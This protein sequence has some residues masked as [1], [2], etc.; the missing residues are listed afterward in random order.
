[1]ILHS[2]SSNL[3]S[4]PLKRLSH[5][6][7]YGKK[8]YGWSNNGKRAAEH[9]SNFSQLL[10]LLINVNRNADGPSEKRDGNCQVF[11]IATGKFSFLSY[12]LLQVLGLF[13]AAFLYPLGISQRLL[14]AF[15]HFPAA[16]LY[17][18]RSTL[19]LFNSL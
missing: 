7:E 1:L 13:P 9:F 12:W 8:W 3:E 14:Y 5:Q 16:I 15:V 19:R 2:L 11:A 18:Y 17:T 10:R 4:V 6:F